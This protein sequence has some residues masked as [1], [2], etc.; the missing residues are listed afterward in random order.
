MFG[1]RFALLMTTWLGVLV[2]VILTVDHWSNRVLPCGSNINGCD[3]VAHDA[4][5]RVF[6]IPVALFGLLAHLALGALAIAVLVRATTIRS[7]LFGVGIG[8][9]V[10]CVFVST[11]F[12][13]RSTMVVHALCN[14][15]L[16]SGL[17]FCLSC[18]L[19]AATAQGRENQAARDCS[20]GVAILVPCALLLTTLSLVL[21]GEPSEPTTAWL[22]A[23]EIGSLKLESTGVQGRVAKGGSEIKGAVHSE[24]S[25]HSPWVVVM[26]GDF[27]CPANHLCFAAVRDQC[28]A[29]ACRFMFRE[30]PLPS[31]HDAAQ[32]AQ[33]AE[34][35]PNET[36]FWR[37]ADR[38]MGDY[39]DDP[40]GVASEVYAIPK[41]QLSARLANPNDASG[42]RLQADEAL[43]KHLGLSQT[44]TFVLFMP[45]QK[46]IVSSYEELM[47]ELKRIENR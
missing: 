27:T 6:G 40:V 31:H 17:L 34:M 8:F 24:G 19:M 13:L 7:R 14:W 21:F 4:W 25:P 5:A 12:T 39:T 37:L 18:G 11:A 47:A 2:T 28:R 29:S 36:L 43:D 23:N 45:S 16:A 41:T 15:C 32:Y 35:A 42:R 38:Y 1:R 33:L 22:N 3:R 26:F 44:P 10:F 46:P 9:A 20:P 30:F